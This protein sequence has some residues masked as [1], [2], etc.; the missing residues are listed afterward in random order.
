MSTDATPKTIQ[1]IASAF[2]RSRALLT[3]FELDIFTTINEQQL[4][5]SEVAEAVGGAPRHVDRLLNALVALGLLEKREGR[6]ANAPVAARY[7]VKGRPGYMGGL[8]HTA[9]L[10]E[11]WGHLTEVVR[12]GR[13][14]A[15]P[16]INDRGDEWLR[17]FIA[18]MHWRSRQ[19][20][21]EVVKALDL[22]GVSRVIDVGGGS[23][24]YAM[25]FA[26]A[27]AGVSAVV[28]DLPNVVPLTRTYIVEESLAAQVEAVAGDYMKD[29]LGEGFDLALLSM[30][31]HSHSPAQNQ[32]L[33]AKV[34][35]ALTS[36]GQVVIQDFLMAEDRG[37]PLQPA[38]FA[39]NMLVGT[40][41]GDTYTDA[42]VRGWLQEA[43]FTSVTRTDTT[44]GSS[45]VVGRR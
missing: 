29:S 19:T 17:P 25:A 35:R 11:T 45:L 3:A 32:A 41:A 22:A 14:A 43:G 31:I 42:E 15:R 8:G 37:G 16:P 38:L 36:G 6:F 21:P 24:A 9:H 1:E 28:F 4:T 13:P 20:A 33:L 5:S 12:E 34:A 23:G 10:W 44:F 30:V 2:Q 18:A 27:K 40:E 39:L 7:L 26:R